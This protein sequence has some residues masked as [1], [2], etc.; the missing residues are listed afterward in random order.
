MNA[1]KERYGKKDLKTLFDGASRI[2]VAKG[3]KVLEF[4]M[5]K[6]PPSAAELEKVVLG[7]TG[8]LRAPALRTGST[9]LVGFHEE[10]YG[11]RFG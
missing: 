4:D 8:N 2:V 7:P 1:T 6:D 11:E 3:K 5:K 9:W 10:A